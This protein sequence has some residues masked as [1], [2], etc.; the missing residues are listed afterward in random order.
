MLSL[1]ASSDSSRSAYYAPVSDLTELE[2]LII[3]GELAAV[4]QIAERFDVSVIYFD[5]GTLVV[6]DYSD[7]NGKDRVHR[8]IRALKAES[9]DV[10][11]VR[12]CEPVLAG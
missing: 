6:D 8:L 1:V 10:K 11:R 12:V 3:S 7:R 4:S 2:E 5:G 9:I